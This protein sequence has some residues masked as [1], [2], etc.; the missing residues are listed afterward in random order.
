MRPPPRGL[1][2]D[3]HR[4]RR[5][6]EPQD[7]GHRPERLPGKPDRQAGPVLLDGDHAGDPEERPEQGRR[8]AL[9]PLAPVQVH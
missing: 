7:L 8:P 5:T 6:P 1:L 4:L 9:A 2:Q 3:L